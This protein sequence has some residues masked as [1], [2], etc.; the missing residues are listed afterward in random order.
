MHIGHNAFKLSMSLGNSR[1]YRVLDI[2]GR[3]FMETAADAV[4]APPMRSA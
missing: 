3:H 2:H 4:S 1:K